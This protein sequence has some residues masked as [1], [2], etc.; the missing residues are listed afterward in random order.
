MWPVGVGAPCFGCVEKGV[1]FT[2]ALH[3][4]SEVTSH[5]SPEIYPPVNH[6]TG[7]GASVSSAGLLGAAVGAAVGASAMA[8]RNLGKAEK[9]ENNTESQDS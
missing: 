6:D 3:E 4:A 2:K 7:T 1:G 9:H 8:V 5:T